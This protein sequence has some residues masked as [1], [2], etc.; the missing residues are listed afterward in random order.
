MLRPAFA[1]DKP[2]KIFYCCQKNFDNE[3]F[4]VELK[5]HLSSA[6]DFEWLHLA[7]KTTLERFASLQQKAVPNN[8]QTFMTK[9]LPKAIMKGSKLKNNFKKERNTK[10][11][12]DYKEQQHY[13]SKLLKDSKTRLFNNLKVENVTENKGFWKT[14]RP[15]FTDE[16][17]NTENY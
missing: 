6:L 15:F 1:R 8:N 5:K 10:N 11:C 4:E 14:I 7:F 3:K 12:S 2:K 16:T 17:K 9:T 13:C